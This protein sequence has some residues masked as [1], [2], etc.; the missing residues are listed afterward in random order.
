MLYLS[1]NLNR[2]G[3]VQ[4]ATITG[5]LKQGQVVVLP[6]DTIYGLSCLAKNVRAI[7]KI[8]NLKKR[9]PHKPLIVL[10]SD[11]NMVKKFTFVS[12]RQ[13][14]FLKKIWSSQEAP[15]TVILKSRGKLPMEISSQVD[16]LAIRL[17]KLKFLIKII[18]AVNH[19]LIST[20]LNLSGQPEIKRV[21]NLENYFPIKKNQPDLVVDIGSSPRKKASRLI[22][23]RREDQVIVLR[24]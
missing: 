11:L 8:Y 5:S 21:K 9:E 10:M 16:G 18:K 14:K 17:P 4:L 3:P 6:T 22:D 2:I 19:P 24:K 7:K 13:E 23:L 1:L 15:T 12:S 20:S